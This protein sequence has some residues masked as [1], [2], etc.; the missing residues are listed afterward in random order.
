[1]NIKPTIR[2][3]VAVTALSGLTL[4][5][6]ACGPLDT[7]RAKDWMNTGVREFN[8]GKYDD[9]EKSFSKSLELNPDDPRAKLFYAMTLNAKFRRSP[10][11]E[12]GG[13]TVEAYQKV[14][15]AKPE[16][17]QIDKA[18]AFIADVYK[19]LV[20]LMDPVKD[21]A[22]VDK[23]KEQRRKWLLD[24]GNLDGQ[25]DT[26]KAQMLYSVGQSFW[27][28]AHNAIKANTKPNPEPGKPPIITIDDP[29]KAKV[30]EL[31]NKGHEYMDQAIAKDKDYADAYAYKKVL[32]TEETKLTADPEKRKELEEKIT[33]YDELYREKASAQRARE[34]EE[35]AK[36]AEKAAKE[37]EAAE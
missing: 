20:D 23:F 9:A 22:K 26:I 29:T 13:K 34:A 2:R 24:R 21:A 1:L 18:Y 3:L 14:I 30:M 28:D 11:E 25:T 8:R 10:T 6:S 17:E 32:F 7:L 36:A 37:G 27:E 35:E 4:G 5:A 12:L 19:Q 15:E 16:F 31:I 33:E